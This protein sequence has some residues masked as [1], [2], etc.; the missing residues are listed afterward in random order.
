MEEQTIL[1]QEIVQLYKAID[2]LPPQFPKTEHF[3]LINDPM[4]LTVDEKTEIYIEG[5]VNSGKEIELKVLNKK[6][7]I[8]SEH[9]FI[10]NGGSIIAGSFIYNYQVNLKFPKK[11]TR[12]LLING[13]RTPP[14]K[15]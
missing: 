2:Q 15:N 11:G 1:N 14:F 8:A 9:I 7:S 12:A 10:Q 13:E 5:S 6:G 4:E 3:N